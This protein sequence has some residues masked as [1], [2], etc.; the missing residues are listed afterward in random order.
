MMREVH[1]GEFLWREHRELEGRQ[2]SRDMGKRSLVDRSPLRV[3][4]ML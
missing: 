3:S 1:Q 4:L 2:S